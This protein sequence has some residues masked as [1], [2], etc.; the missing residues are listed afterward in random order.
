MNVSAIIKP[1]VSMAIFGSI[2]FFPIHTGLPATELVFI[3]CVCAT[4]FLGALWLITGG[5]KT[6]VWNKKE[7]LRTLFMGSLSS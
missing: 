7:L 3:R 6:E 2:G 5:H 4:L 1:T